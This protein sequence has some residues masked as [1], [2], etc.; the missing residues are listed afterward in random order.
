MID[1][2]ATPQEAVAK[3]FDGMTVMICGFRDVGAPNGMVPYMMDAGLKDMTLIGIDAGSDKTEGFGRLVVDKRFKKLMVTHVGW[4]PKVTEQVNAGELELELIPQGTLAERIRCG[5][6]GLGGVL[7][8]TGVGTTVAEGKE[9]I[10]IDGKDYLLEKP[11][12]ADVA[13]IK[14]N[15]GDRAGNLVYH[16][17][18]RNF[19]TV[20]AMA[21][22]FVVAEV[23]ELVEVGEIN[24][25]DVVI[26]G[27]CVDMIVKP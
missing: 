4:N 9:T 20:M 18:A 21:A 24:P 25:D 22:D 5:G 26:P 17:C 7:T 19:N 6:Y 14:A 8:P 10:T 16:G 2:V 12:R 23:D 15:K 13:V 27:C 3:M 1:K 11:L